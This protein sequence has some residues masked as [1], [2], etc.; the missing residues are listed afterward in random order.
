M[1]NYVKKKGVY[2]TIFIL[3]LGVPFLSMKLVFVVI[4]AVK[5]IN[6]ITYK[7]LKLESLK[8][9]IFYLHFLMLLVINATFLRFGCSE[10]NLNM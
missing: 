5:S 9:L 6:R 4:A 2:S 1:D 3:A 8:K 10:G 7:E